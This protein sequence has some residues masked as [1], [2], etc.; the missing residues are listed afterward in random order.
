MIDAHAETVKTL[1]ATPPILRALTRDVGDER[2]RR[3]PAPGEWSVVE[4]VA[5]MR[6]VEQQALERVRRMLAEDRP[7]LAAF[8]H[9][10]HARDRNYVA[11]RLQETVEQYVG[12]R[13]EHLVLLDGLG[14]EGQRRAGRHEVHG[15]VTVA[16]YEVHVAAEDVDHLAQ[17]AR[18]L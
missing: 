11:L 3:A 9:E 15:D 12:L 13:K 8:D 6:D 1:R 18:M 7:S 5:H 16:S 14:P 17:I 4:V 2:A 10:Q